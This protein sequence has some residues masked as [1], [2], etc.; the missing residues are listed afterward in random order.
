MKKIAFY[1][2]RIFRLS[3][4]YDK[5]VEKVWRDLKKLHTT[6]NWNSGVFE[7]EKYI[8]TIFTIENEKPARFNYFIHNGQYVCRCVILENY[9]EDATTDLFVLATHFN[10]L[11]IDG[12]VVVNINTQSVEYIYKREILIPLL[13]TGEIEGQLFKHFNTAKDIYWGFKRLI[14]ENEAS[15]IIIADLFKKIDEEKNSNKKNN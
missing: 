4:A 11:L 14:E 12:V 2:K 6:S 10:N 3:L 5:Q 8:D 9:S 1:F 15:A 7:K 13:Y